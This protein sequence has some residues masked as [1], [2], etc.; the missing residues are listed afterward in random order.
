MSILWDKPAIDKK[1][2]LLTTVRYK[3]ANARKMQEKIDAIAFLAKTG[4]HIHFSATLSK[5]NRILREYS[6]NLLHFFLKKERKSKNCIF[7][8]YW[9]NNVEFTKAWPIF[10]LH[11]DRGSRRA[12]AALNP[13]ARLWG[14]RKG[15]A[16]IDRRVQRERDRSAPAASKLQTGWSGE[17]K[18]HC[19]DSCNLA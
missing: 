10:F 4:F 11:A 14:G 3:L 9:I 5:I 7:Y 8:Y 12:E 1:S 6:K 13:S 17:E 15:A 19:Q 18:L 16:V 2:E